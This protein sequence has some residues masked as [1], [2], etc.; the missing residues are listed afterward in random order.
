MNFE[1]S[2]FE[3]YEWDDCWMEK[4]RDREAKR[5][6]Y[7]GDSIARGTRRRA[8]ALSRERLLFDGYSTSKGV[9]NPW[10]MEQLRLFAQ[11]IYR[12]AAVLFN[13]GLHGFH[14]RLEEY[15]ACY[16]E[17]LL[18]LQKLFPDV[19]VFP[20]L[21]TAVTQQRGEDIVRGRNDVVRK[22]AEKHS[23]KI[24]DLYSVSAEREGYLSD[25]GIHPVPMGYELLAKELLRSLEEYGIL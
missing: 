6:L 13:N 9:D 4:A 25:D 18:F 24:I 3:T 7:I 19:P 2:V 11:Q 16:E 12:P 14:L 17:V 22:L 8:T 15:S 21:T 23:L 5:V 1:K 20:V 10:L